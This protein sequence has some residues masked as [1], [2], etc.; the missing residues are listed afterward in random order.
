MSRH[1][2][3]DFP[4]EALDRAGQVE[5][6]ILDVDGT[7][8][9]GRLYMGPRGQEFKTFHVRDGLGLKLLIRAG[10]RVAVISGRSSRAVALRTKELGIHFLYQGCENKLPVFDE[11]VARCGI[12]PD[13]W[14]VL[15]DDVL[16]LCIME[17]AGF[18]V[19]VADCAPDLIPRI[20]FRT[21]NP[22]GHGAVREVCELILKSRGLWP[23][24]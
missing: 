19:G 1:S 14:A 15:G 3:L 5:G 10:I 13:R 4:P 9:D 2:D 6:L 23:Y 22:G 24:R 16:D 17:R 20:H 8:T 18:S 21:R 11:L 7:L 12:P